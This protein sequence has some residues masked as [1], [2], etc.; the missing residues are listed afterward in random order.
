MREGAQEI[1]ACSHSCAFAASFA[2]NVTCLAF[3][4][5][6]GAAS[7]PRLFFFSDMFLPV[8]SI[9]N[10]KFYWK[11][12]EQLVK[13]IFFPPRNCAAFLNRRAVARRKRKLF[14]T[15]VNVVSLDNPTKLML[16]YIPVQSAGGGPRLEIL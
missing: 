5:D 6:R 1:C 16:I 9:R 8:S 10:N 12:Q 15:V 13:T 11:Q 7:R 4:G 14:L 3:T 2:G